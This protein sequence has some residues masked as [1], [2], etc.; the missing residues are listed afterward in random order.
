MGATAI[1]PSGR[2]R[3]RLRSRDR[4]HL[5][6]VAE[7]MLDGARQLPYL[8]PASVRRMGKDIL[9]A[10]A[11]VDAPGYEDARDQIASAAEG[12]V[13][14][15][16]TDTTSAEHELIRQ[17]C[18]VRQRLLAEDDLIYTVVFMP[19]HASMWD[20]LHSIWMAAD[21]DP[22]VEAIVVPIPYADR[23]PNGDAGEWHL[24]LTD[25]PPEVSVTPFTE[26]DLKGTHP[27]V[28]YVHNPY[29]ANNRVT[30]VAPQFYSS[31]LRP[32]TDLL[33]YVPYYVSATAPGEHLYRS[34]SFEL[35]DKVIA[36]SEEI[37]HAV[38]E[39]WTSSKVV[40]LG[41]PKFDYVR[42]PGSAV[43]EDWAVKAEGRVVLL[44]LTSLAAMMNAPGE[45][46]RKLHD[47]L[48]AVEASED[49]ALWWRPHPLERATVTSMIPQLDALYTAYQDRA[50]RSD[51]VIVDTSLDLQRAI[52][53][54]DA[55]FGHWS[56]VTELF[57]FTGKPMVIQ[58]VNIKTNERRP[59]GPQD[60]GPNAAL[61]AFARP[62]SFT[63]EG[64]FN[65]LRRVLTETGGKVPGQH[66]YFAS[67]TAHSDGT[68]GQ[69]IHDYVIS[70]VTNR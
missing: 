43:P 35:F 34:P 66:E 18:A 24:H 21:A 31:A 6:A 15:F 33:V 46:V 56:S 26:F 25:L 42:T 12:L 60:E 9:E 64:A 41:S 44:Q 29:D 57:G 11:L 13:G 10:V 23:L 40:P 22:R 65:Y 8:E 30:T 47:V 38:I 4:K 58:E 14:A 67:L 28:I 7:S 2:E 27:D 1:E 45:V 54:A 32:H 69:H 51:R 37:D 39:T 19:Y 50:A 17:L 36:Q 16:A 5:L 55:Y 3:H 48:D 52:H 49:L 61:T 63:Y 59:E 68:A 20:S 70:C 62:E 53:N